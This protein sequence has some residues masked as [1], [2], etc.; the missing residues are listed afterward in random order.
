M[1][2]KIT[3]P[4]PCHENWEQMTETEKGKFC[5]VCQKNLT[6][7]ST[8]SN[9]E[10]F[11]ELQSQKG[12]ICGWFRADQLD[13]YIYEIKPAEARTWPWFLAGALSLLGFQ[14]QVVAQD[15]RPSKPA[16][17][18][19]ISTENAAGNNSN[20]LKEIRGRLTTTEGTAISNEMVYLK[21]MPY[22]AVTDSSGYFTIYVRESL[23]T[24]SITL[25]LFPYGANMASQKFS[26]NQIANG[27]ILK[28]TVDTDYAK[29]LGVFITGAPA[30][31]VADEK[32]AVF[33]GYTI[34][35]RNGLF[36][37]FKNWIR[38]IF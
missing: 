38:R 19:S 18:A 24:D 2:Y 14:N 34:A 10:L 30:T 4:E 6:D 17:A 29:S 11:N 25:T 9:Q 33:L 5:A 15:T 16:A 13:R 23:K 1:K 12:R 31:L 36:A 32:V 21:E 27:E 37:R 7:F 35:E 3:I 8:Y 28:F 22:E 26:R 20:I